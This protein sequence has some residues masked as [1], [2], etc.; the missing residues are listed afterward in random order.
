MKFESK[1]KLLNE[2]VREFGALDFDNAPDIVIFHKVGVVIDELD[3]IDFHGNGLLELETI[4]INNRA[5]Q[6][7]E[8]D[9]FFEHSDWKHE[10]YG[11]LTDKDTSW[12]YYGNEKTLFIVINDPV[13]LRDMLSFWVTNEFT[14]KLISGMLNNRGEI[15]E[16]K[17]LDCSGINASFIKRLSTENKETWDSIDEVTKKASCI[18]SRYMQNVIVPEDIKYVVN[19]VREGGSEKVMETITRVTCDVLRDKATDKI[20]EFTKSEFGESVS[21]LCGRLLGLNKK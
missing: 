10:D 2:I 20:V 9:G 17:V 7:F 14:I 15:M 6:K 16:F 12:T 21:D 19:L 11:W 4:D 18:S 13:V 8:E 1:V 5:V 3:C